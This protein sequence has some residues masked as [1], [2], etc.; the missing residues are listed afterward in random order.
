MAKEK[1]LSKNILDKGWLDKDTYIVI[2]ADEIDKDGDKYHLEVE[3]H[4][5]EKGYTFQHIYE[6]QVIDTDITDELKSN[7][8]DFIQKNIAKSF[9]NSK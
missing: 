3:Y 2:F 4:L 7:I 9:G 8:K 1:I 5:D 6:H